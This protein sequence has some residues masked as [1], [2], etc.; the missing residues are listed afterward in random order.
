MKKTSTESHSVASHLSQA[1]ARFTA[2]GNKCFLIYDGNIVL[3]TASELNVYLLPMERQQK[4]RRS[5]RG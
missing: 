3:K 1:S 4:E 2:E 5:F